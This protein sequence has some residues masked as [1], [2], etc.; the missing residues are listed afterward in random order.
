MA[1]IS[2][3][4]FAETA[5]PNVKPTRKAMF[6]PSNR[7]PRE[8]ATMPRQT[9]AMRDTRI[10]CFSSALPFFRTEA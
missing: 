9:V 3:G 4:K 10:S 2:T 8:I 6:W 7:M 1:M 5:M